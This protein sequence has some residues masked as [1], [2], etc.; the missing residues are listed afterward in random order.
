MSSS[1]EF[2]QMFAGRCACRLAFNSHNGSQFGDVGSLDEN[3][4]SADESHCL[5]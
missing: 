4:K 2:L 1:L 3:A 5:P